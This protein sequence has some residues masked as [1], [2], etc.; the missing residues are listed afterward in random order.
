MNLTNKMRR[1]Y[2]SGIGRKQKYVSFPE[3]L[4]ALCVTKGGT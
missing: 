3:T 2:G 4:S 1:V